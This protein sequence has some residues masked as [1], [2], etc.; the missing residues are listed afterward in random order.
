MLEVKASPSL[1]RGGYW[2]GKFMK[3]SS[4]IP[5]YMCVYIY[6]CIYIYIHTHTHTH[7]DYLDA[8]IGKIQ[9]VKLRFP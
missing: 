5:L 7:S 3:G 2:M 4:E 1:L 9:V 8:Y 6:I